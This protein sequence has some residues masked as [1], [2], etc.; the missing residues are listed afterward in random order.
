MDSEHMLVGQQ[1]SQTQNKTHTFPTATI[2]KSL[3]K[4]HEKNKA[5]SLT[6]NCL[7]HVNEMGALSYCSSTLPA[8]MLP[9]MMALCNCIPPTP[10]NSSSVRCLGHGVL[11]QHWNS[12]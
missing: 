9:T 12:N 11:S 8:A 5:E 10:T 1:F 6:A 4:P 7:L 3:Q 2:G